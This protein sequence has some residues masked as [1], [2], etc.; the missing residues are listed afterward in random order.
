MP[1]VNENY[2]MQYTCYISIG[3][4]L[5]DRVINCEKA[6]K[7]LESFAT[8][9]STSS[10]YETEPWGYEDNQHYINAVL[11]LETPLSSYDFLYEL[12]M[13]EIS[14]GRLKKQREVVYESRIIDLDI[15]FFDDIIIHNEKLIIPHPKL[16]DRQ[17]V[18]IPFVEIEP[19]FICP[20]TNKR[21]IDLFRQCKDLSRVFLYTH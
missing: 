20:S 17:Y 8:I 3:S 15:L 1:K 5:G 19:N 2:S 14:M 6:M 18:L 21:I 11:K 13:I 7:K 4:N 16:H 12:K 9:L 10:F